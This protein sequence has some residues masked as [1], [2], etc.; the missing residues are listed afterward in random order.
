LNASLYRITDFIAPLP[1]EKCQS[2]AGR[3]ID[4]HAKVL[5]V[6]LKRNMVLI[7]AKEDFGGQ[8]DGALRFN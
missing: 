1:F 7:K 5:Y 2:T 4:G 3:D 6:D 8:L